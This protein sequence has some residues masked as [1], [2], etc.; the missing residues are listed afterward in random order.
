MVL[1]KKNLKDEKKKTEV[2]PVASP[3]KSAKSGENKSNLKFGV[4]QSFQVTEKS[5]N[6]LGYNQY[7]FLVKDSA[8]KPEVEKAVEA[9]YRV[10]VEKVRMVILPGKERRRGQQLGWKPGVKKAIVTLAEGQKIE[11]S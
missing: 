11:V 9:K 6:L 3:D 2:K 4:L 7:V 8:N 10:K 1:F 5:S